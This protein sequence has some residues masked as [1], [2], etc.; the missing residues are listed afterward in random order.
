MKCSAS[1]PFLNSGCQDPWHVNPR[2]SLPAC[3][4]VTY[5]RGSFCQGPMTEVTNATCGRYGG[6]DGQ[7]WDR[8]Y[9]P[10]RELAGLHRDGKKCKTPCHQTYYNVETS[11]QSKEKFVSFS[12][13]PLCRSD[14]C[15]SGLTWGSRSMVIKQSGPMLSRS[16]I[17]HCYKKRGQ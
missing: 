6:W 2:V 17:S 16:F 7:F 3:T 4:N 11:Y 1:Y 15:T 5:I 9:M 12:F 8:H 13:C 14:S 10:E